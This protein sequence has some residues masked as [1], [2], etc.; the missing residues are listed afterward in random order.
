VSLQPPNWLPRHFAPDKQCN[1]YKKTDNLLLEESTSV[2]GTAEDRHRFYH[3]KMPAFFTV[4][5]RK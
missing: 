2:T 1:I 5:D 3:F 4:I